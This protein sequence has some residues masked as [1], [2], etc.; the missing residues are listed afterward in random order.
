M[1]WADTKLPTNLQV[2]TINLLIRRDQFT[3]GPLVTPGNLPACVALPH[4]VPVQTVCT[5]D[6]EYDRGE[7][8]TGRGDVL[9][10]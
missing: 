5:G 6:G 8:R 4:N 2:I 3:D 7:M 9:V 1:V 10:A